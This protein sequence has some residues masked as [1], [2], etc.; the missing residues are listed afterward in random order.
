MRKDEERWKIPEGIPVTKKLGRLLRELEEAERSDP[1]ITDE[2]PAFLAYQGALY[3]AVRAEDVTLIRPAIARRQWLEAVGQSVYELRKRREG[4][5]IGM[6]WLATL[7]VEYLRAKQIY[8]KARD[9]KWP[10]PV[11]NMEEVAAL[12]ARWD[13]RD[14]KQKA[15]RLAPR[16]AATDGYVKTG[17]TMMVDGVRVPIVESCREK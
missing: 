8:D 17:R 14:A 16:R 9:H 7:R 4:L 3:E 6:W 15:R 13:D 1:K 10:A 5:G 11:E 2:H 12:A